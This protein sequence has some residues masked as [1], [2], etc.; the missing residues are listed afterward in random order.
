MHRSGGFT[1]IQA[2]RDLDTA[3]M[4]PV[5]AARLRALIAALDLDALA[6][7][8]LTGRPMPDG[9]TYRFTVERDG[10]RWQFTVREPDVSA[11]VQHLLDHLRAAS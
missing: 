7:R 3:T 9:F 5:Q 4:P 6:A 8:Q 1:G 11:P 10:R 2:R